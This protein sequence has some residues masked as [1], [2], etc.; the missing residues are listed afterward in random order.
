MG[1]D[2]SA[3]RATVPLRFIA[4]RANGSVLAACQVGGKSVR[5]RKCLLGCA[6]LEVAGLDSRVAFITVWSSRPLTCKVTARRRPNRR[7]A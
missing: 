2:S 4:A 5:G 3:F 7:S 6:R 1:Q